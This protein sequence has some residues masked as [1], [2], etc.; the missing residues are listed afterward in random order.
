MRDLFENSFKS[1]CFLSV[2]IFFSFTRIINA[3]SHNGM[4]YEN[5]PEQQWTWSY[6]KVFSDLEC[7]KNSKLNQV[8]FFKENVR[9]IIKENGNYLLKLK[10]PFLG[11]EKFSLF[12][13]GEELIIEI[14]N[15]RCAI[16]L[17]HFLSL[18]NPANGE[19]VNGKLVI[20]FI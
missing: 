5:L 14:A 1:I 11:K 17:P 13:K 16:I 7:V 3:D 12:K 9:E 2:L 20:T 4:C 15:Q 18:L 6:K 19:W 8:I 10:L